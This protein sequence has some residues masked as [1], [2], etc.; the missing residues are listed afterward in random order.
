MAAPFTDYQPIAGHA[1]AYQFAAPDGSTRTL[2]GPAALQVKRTIDSTRQLAGPPPPGPV[3]P[4]SAQ[5]PILASAFAP[6]PQAAGPTDYAGQFAA[7][8]SVR[9]PPP[10]PETV[11]ASAQVAPQG[12]P[13]QAQQVGQ[14]P[15]GQQAPGAGGISMPR[16]ATVKDGVLDTT[17]G[18]VRRAGTAGASKAQIEAEK[19]AQAEQAESMRLRAEESEQRTVEKAQ[20]L[21][22]NADAQQRFFEEQRSK[23]ETSALNEEIRN[24]EIAD[25]ITQERGAVD[26]TMADY[27]AAKIDPD[28]FFKGEKGGTNKLTTAISVMFGA[29]AHFGQGL[30][31]NANGT[32]PGIALVNKRIDDDI[33]E[34]ERE[35]GVKKEA[36]D[37]ALAQL[38]RSLGDMQQAK[39]GLK[40]M[41]T[42]VAVAKMTELA[43]ATK[44][45]LV[46][47]QLGEQIAVLEA[48]KQAALGE[49]ARL[50][51]LKLRSMRGSGPSTRAAT[52]DEI[53]TVG[54]IRATDAGTEK[55][56]V[57]AYSAA[58]KAANAANGGAPP[59][60]PESGRQ[61]LS[62]RAG[63]AAM[64]KQLAGDASA[65]GKPWTP[66]G[67]N[68]LA[69]TARGALDTVAGAGTYKDAALSGEEKA[70]SDRFNNMR[71]ALISIGTQLT[72]AGAPSEGEA[73]RSAAG[74]AQTEEQLLNIVKSNKQILGGKLGAYGIKTPQVDIKPE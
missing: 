57:E 20:I 29:L 37:G 42:D 35:I 14:L 61:L 24:R 23:A 32:N 70:R 3:A 65:G 44:S 2:T 54:G 1:D 50:G 59:D 27:R 55:T 33:R 8:P 15:P 60:L 52:L 73:L 22:E 56:G 48:Q 28:R 11:P 9:V 66:E 46:R 5:P 63:L 39:L 43:N 10:G 4:P 71:Q 18:L 25:R 51:E 72:G 47:N 12:L 45:P 16:F 7:A 69:S 31:G 67:Q 49:F 74:S 68:I 41:Q 13:P 26:A 6:P 19:K 40:A 38:H 58:Q 62:A 17:T 21:S 53:K 34:Q 30:M 64:E 36:S